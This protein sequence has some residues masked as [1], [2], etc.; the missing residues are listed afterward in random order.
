M[1]TITGQPCGPGASSGLHTLTNKQS[2]LS[3]A[4]V[5]RLCEFCKHPGA[6]SSASATPVQGA[7]GC[8]AAQRRAPE[9]GAAYR[10]PFHTCVP[11]ATWPRTAPHV[12]LANTYCTACPLLPDDAAAS[13]AASSKEDAAAAAAT[14]HAAGAMLD[15]GR[16]GLRSSLW[17]PTRPL[18]GIA[19]SLR[20]SLAKDSA[21]SRR[22]HRLA[23]ACHA[24]CANR[25]T[26]SS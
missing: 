18:D 26:L 13:A 3:S 15:E 21:L 7:G 25:A 8:G 19:F 14:T 11:L 4:G 24:L 2:S 17:L 10:T 9:A 5:S 22:L 23:H 1:N 16:V 6:K 20:M 12:V